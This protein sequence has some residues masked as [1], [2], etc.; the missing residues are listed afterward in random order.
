M[1]AICGTGMGSLAGLLKNKGYEICGS[2]NNVYPPMSTELESQNIPVLSPYSAENMAQAKPDLVIVGNAVSK[3]NPEADFLIHSDIPHVSM[4]QALNYFFLSSKE[5]IVVSGT[6]G[7]TTTTSLMAFLLNELGTDPSFLVGGVTN[8][9]ARNFR[10]GSGK[11]FVIEGDEYDTAY[12]DK[13]PKFLHYNPTHVIMTSLEFDH[14][15][16]YQNLEQI[17]ESFIKLAKIIPQTGSLHY[18]DSCKTLANVVGHCQANFKRSYGVNSKDWKI[19]DFK[20]TPTGSEFDLFQ[21]SKKLLH[22]ESPLSGLYNAENV[23]SCF[24]VLEHLGFDLKKTAAA[25]KNFKSVRRRQE[26][27]LQNKDYVIID[28]FAHHPTAVEKTILAIREKLPK[29]HLV[30]VFEPRSNTSRRA[31]FQEAYTQSFTR[32]DEVM[33]AHVNQ[34]EKVADGNIL[35]VKKII[36]TL[37]NQQKPAH[38]PL[39]TEEI[40][41]TILAISHRPLAILIMSNG[42]FDGLCQKLVSRINSR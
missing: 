40:I 27:V 24:S 37:K 42:N 4:P 16:I 15:D 5:V 34:P 9:F 31:V 10:I 11:Y 2:D 12:F 32:A 7:K 3:T 36:E 18:S 22:I 23:S 30:A 39:S 1:L 13:G 8:N 28:D 17:T 35:D 26:I 6:H 21:N 29:H 41:K 38:Y 14:A 20:P 25:L 19:S 33:I